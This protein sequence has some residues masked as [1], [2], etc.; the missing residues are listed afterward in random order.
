M[1]KAIRRKE[2]SAV[3]L[4]DLHLRRIEDVNPALNAVVYS[5][6]ERAREEARAA[7][8]ALTRGEAEGPLHGVPMTIKEA[9]ESA[10]VPC[11]GGTLGRKGFIGARD[12]PVVARV[13]AAGAISA[14]RY[15]HAGAFDG[16]RV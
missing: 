15:E 5:L 1:A 12:S 3:E 14:W 6:A 10:G 16:I 2:I 13:R 11:T 9:W 8:A 7:D 4:V